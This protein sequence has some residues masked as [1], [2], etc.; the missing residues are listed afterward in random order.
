ME[1][2]IELRIDFKRL[3]ISLLLGLCIMPVPGFSKD[4]DNG[5]YQCSAGQDGV[6]V[7][8]TRTGQ[9]WELG[10]SSTIDYGTPQN[11]RFQRAYITPPEVTPMFLPVKSQIINGF[12]GLSQGSTYKLNNGQIWVQTD[13]YSCYLSPAMPRATICRGYTGYKM[14]VDGIDVPVAVQQIK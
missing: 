9:L 7:I 12:N 2:K 3:V 14:I 6:F 8:N 4:N 5:P 10:I 1:N 11:R 13:F